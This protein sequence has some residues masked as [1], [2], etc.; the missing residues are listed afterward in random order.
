MTHLIGLQKIAKAFATSTK[1]IAHWY[2]EG[3]PIWRVGV[4]YQCIYEHLI[5]WLEKNYSVRP[6]SCQLP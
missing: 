2:Q 6:K 4:T 1:R 3:A 5:L